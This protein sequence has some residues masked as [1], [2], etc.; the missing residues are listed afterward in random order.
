MERLLGFEKAIR[1]IGKASADHYEEKREI[2]SFWNMEGRL[3]ELE[4]LDV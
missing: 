3:G 2:R 4:A 1:K